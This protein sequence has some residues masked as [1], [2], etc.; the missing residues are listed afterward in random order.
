M[1]VTKVD[2]ALQVRLRKETGAP[3]TTC[4]TA[5]LHSENDYDAALNFIRQNVGVKDKGSGARAYFSCAEGEGG[6]AV[7]RVCAS[8]RLIIDTSVV[9]SVV[10]EISGDAGRY[11][12]RDSLVPLVEKCQIAL[13]EK[14]T[15]ERVLRAQESR[16]EVYA[17]DLHG[18][19][20]FGGLLLLQYGEARPVRRTDTL[21]DLH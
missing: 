6:L 10:E 12:S 2:T 19:V 8:D 11:A 13:Q 1:A 3:L 20:C 5:L 7:Y 15:I 18:G 17:H 21:A 16:S 4:R 9:R 14:V